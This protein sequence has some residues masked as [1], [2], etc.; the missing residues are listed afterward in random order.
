MNSWTKRDHGHKGQTYTPQQTSP[1]SP[2][3]R[4]LTSVDPGAAAFDTG[5]YSSACHDGR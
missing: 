2:P 3:P 5:Q 4:M 1:A